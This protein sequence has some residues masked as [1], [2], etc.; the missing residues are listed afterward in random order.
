M[1]IFNLETFVN[2][3]N[4]GKTNYNKY[5]DTDKSEKEFEIKRKK[6]ERSNNTSKENKTKRN[7]NVFKMGEKFE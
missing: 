3:D 4:V 5:E 1:K 6:K 2:R 7:W